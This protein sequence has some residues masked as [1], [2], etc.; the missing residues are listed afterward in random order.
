MAK[1]N[2]NYLKLPSRSLFA[3]VKARV[4][5]FKEK[6]PNAD[7]INLCVDDVSQPLPPAVIKAMH[8]ALDEMSTA[9]TF[10]GY[11]QEQ[12]FDFLIRAIINNDY[13]ARN[14]K[15][16]EDEVFVS[17]GVKCDAGNLQELFSPNSVVAITDPIYPVFL[18]SNVIA[19]RGGKLKKNGCFEDIVYLP[20][21]AKND[22][23]PQLPGKKVDI[24]Y[25]CSPNNPTGAVLTKKQLKKWVDYAREQKSVIIYDSV[26]EAYITEQD[27]PHSIYE[28][29]GAQEVAVECRSFSQQAG[30]TGVRCAYTIVPKALSGKAGNENIPLNKLWRRRQCAKSNEVSYI[31]QKGAEASYSEEGRAQIRQVID[32][33]MENAGTIRAGLAPLDLEVYGGV[34][35]PYIWL[36]TP[37]GMDSWELFDHFLNKAHVIGA[38]GAMFGNSGKNYLRLAAFGDAEHVKEAVER[39]NKSFES[40][41]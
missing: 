14:I 15:I 3:E 5:R 22:F 33:C 38:P 9:K 18:D 27:I 13:L 36:K 8:K 37:R 31:T 2:R 40:F 29:P 17:D 7:I 4:D 24:I 21:T 39:I 26:Y 16:S 28:I 34:N 25:I 32:Y 20:C 12:G 6:R 30:F 1:V 10:R 11:S 35:A 41:E 23:N 19:G